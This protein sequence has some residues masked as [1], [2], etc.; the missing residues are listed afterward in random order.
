MA[1]RTVLM[2]HVHPQAVFVDGVE[3]RSAERCW[4]RGKW[5]FAEAHREYP[6]LGEGFLMIP[7][8]N[9]LCGGS[10]VNDPGQRKIGTVLRHGLADISEAEM[11]LLDGTHLGKVG[12]NSI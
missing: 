2:G 5:N 7:A 8:F 12:D 4:V 9:S 1:S 11:V 6:V 10:H 3:T